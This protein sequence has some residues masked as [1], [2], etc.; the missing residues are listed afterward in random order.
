MTQAL[1]TQRVVHRPATSASSG[2]LLEMRNLGP[3]SGTSELENEMTKWVVCT[4]NLNKP[5][6]RL[7]IAELLRRTLMEIKE[8][9]MPTPSLSINCALET[10]HYTA[11][12]R[13]LRSPYIRICEGC[14]EGK[15]GIITFKCC[16]QKKKR[17]KW[18]QEHFIK[19]KFYKESKYITHI[20]RAILPKLAARTSGLHPDQPEV[21][22]LDP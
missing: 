20:S 17:K 1:P 21:T 11:L 8:Q 12:G 3:C 19:I 9:W 6:I 13:S 14:R 7:Y 16:S 15:V 10:A 2:S 22:S 18:T 4:L 5:W